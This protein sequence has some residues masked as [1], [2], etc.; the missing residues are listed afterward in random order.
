MTNDYK[1]RSVTLDMIAARGLI[2]S[3]EAAP[4]GAQALAP[5][6]Q[7]KLTADTLAPSGVAVE[8]R[9]SEQGSP[10]AQPG[11]KSLPQNSS[12]AKSLPPGPPTALAAKSLPPG[13]PAVLAAKALPPGPPAVLAAKALPPGPPAVLAAKALPPGPPMA[14]AAKALPPG[15]PAAPPSKA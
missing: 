15:P 6:Q 5:D 8:Y 7:L 12:V 4:A 14:L 11:V 10:A 3:V 13:P 1:P 9:L 2:A